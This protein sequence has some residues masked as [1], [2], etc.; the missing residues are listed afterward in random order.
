MREVAAQGPT[1]LSAMRKGSKSRVNDLR[2]DIRYL[3]AA[4]Y[5]QSFSTS[6]YSLA[7]DIN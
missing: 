3:E 1:T 6:N 4:G 7:T 2:A 5:S